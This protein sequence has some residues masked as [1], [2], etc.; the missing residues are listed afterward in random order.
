MFEI[1]CPSWALVH[2][3][4]HDCANL[5]S[6]DIYSPHQQDWELGVS[7]TSSDASSL[8]N[9]GLIAL[10]GILTAETNSVPPSKN[11]TLETDNANE[12]DGGESEWDMLSQSGSD[13]DIVSEV[14]MDAC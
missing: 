8:C 14:D 6:N 2:I 11:V 9:A 10:S 5:V 13:W 4:W 7:A 12:E 3:S 1:H